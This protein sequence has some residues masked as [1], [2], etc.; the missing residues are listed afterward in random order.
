[1]RFSFEK[2]SVPFSVPVKTSRGVFPRRESLVVTLTPEDGGRREAAAGSGECAPWIGFGCESLGDAENFLRTLRGNAPE[3]IPARFPCLAHA[4]S[5][6]KF[7]SEHPELR[8]LP[9]PKNSER[10]RLLPRSREDSPEKILSVLAR[11]RENGFRVFKIKIGLGGEPAEE[12]NFC[13]KILRGVPAG[14]RI[15][16]DANG[17]FPEKILPALC[18]LSAAPA[19]EFFE[20]P[21]PPSPENDGKIFAAAEKCGG[22]FALDE[23]VRAPWAFPRETPVVAVVKPLLIGDFPR[24]LAWLETPAGADVVVSSVFENSAAG[25]DAL[26]LACSRVAGKRRRAFGLG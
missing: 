20:Q 25:R 17:A 1:M 3:K 23:S 16:F 24:L 18:A 4:F 26:F 8:G 7:F 2:I 13:E 10:A 12:L 14:T 11:E 6:A 9:P 19:L 15:R 21:L 22:K 5:A